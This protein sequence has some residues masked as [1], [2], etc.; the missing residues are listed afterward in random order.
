[1]TDFTLLSP[2]Q[3]VAFVD[4]NFDKFSSDRPPEFPENITA[5]VAGHLWVS[6][7]RKEGFALVSKGMNG[8]PGI[9][10]GKNAELMFLH[11]LKEFEGR[12]IASHLIEE[13][14]CA[15]PLGR[16]LDVKCEGEKRVRFF[17]RRG[18]EMVNHDVDT[19]LYYLQW[20]AP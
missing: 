4:E 10:A 5:S 7:T 17:N 3:I 13:A 16:T 18:F 20:S 14:K 1:M 8:I 15:I 6:I 2:Q 12:G 9:M 19:D 11:V